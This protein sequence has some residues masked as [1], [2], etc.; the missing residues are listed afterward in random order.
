MT[1]R[2]KNSY[3][4]A[5]TARDGFVR[6]RQWMVCWNFWTQVIV[7]SLLCSCIL[8][9]MLTWKISCI[10][11][12]ADWWL[13]QI[14]LTGLRPIDEGLSIG[15]PA[16]WCWLGKRL[17]PTI[18]HGINSRNCD[19]KYVINN[20]LVSYKRLHFLFL[21]LSRSPKMIVSQL[22][23]KCSHEYICTLCVLSCALSMW[24]QF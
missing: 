12:W 23:G 21:S 10:I 4:K 2:W 7:L 1:T 17:H 11:F 19:E 18:R 14:Q 13:F 22:I 20:W 3:K 8:L 24:L 16:G 6:Y 15:R 9:K 5:S